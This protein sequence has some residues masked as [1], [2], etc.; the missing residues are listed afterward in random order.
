MSRARRAAEAGVIRT[1]SRLEHIEPF[2]LMELAKAAMAIAHSPECDPAQG[3]EPMVFLNIG[4]PDFTAAPAVREAAE[5]CLRGG[6]T[7]YTQATG[8]PALRE[9]IAA[10]YGSRFGVAVDPGRIVVTAGASAA[11]QLALTLDIVQRKPQP[12]RKAR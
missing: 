2:Y 11:L 8:L 5:R 9:R 7:Q 4:E 6:H 12:V 3:G 1:A 10:W